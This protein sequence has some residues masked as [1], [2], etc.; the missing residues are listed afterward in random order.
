M[1]ASLVFHG[2]SSLVTPAPLVPLGAVA[3]TPA[4]AQQYEIS[5]SG[6][7]NCN[8]IN[9]PLAATFYGGEALSG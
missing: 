6:S 7:M 5:F 1:K 9:A 2:E 3:A 4:V 8:S